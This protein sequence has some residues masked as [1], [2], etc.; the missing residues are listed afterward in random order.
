MKAIPIISYNKM[1]DIHSKRNCQ[2]VKIRY[3]TSLVFTQI[4]E[5]IL[6]QFNLIS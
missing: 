6:V 4:I 2:Q 3:K 1:Q 5:Y